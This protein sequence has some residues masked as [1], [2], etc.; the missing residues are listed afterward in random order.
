MQVRGRH[1]LHE[2]YA[3]APYISVPSCPVRPVPPTDVA[4]PL[5]QLKPYA[6]DTPTFAQIDWM[7]Y[8]LVIRA[9]SAPAVPPPPGRGP[10]LR[11][12]MPASADFTKSG[13]RF[14]EPSKHPSD[15][16]YHFLI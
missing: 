15:G 13:Q 2:R 5:F 11:Y 4:T 9:R 1:A 12:A 14:T 8:P 7:M 16:N 6:Y 10:S 3:Y